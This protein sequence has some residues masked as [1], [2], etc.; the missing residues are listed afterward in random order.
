MNFIKESFKTFIRVQV[1]LLFTIL[2]FSSCTTGYFR[3]RSRVKEARNVVKRFI[4]PRAD[5]INFKLISD[6]QGKPGQM[7]YQI[8]AHH[9]RVTIKGNTGVALCRGAYTYLKE[10]CHCMFTWGGKHVDI[11][12]SWP[13]YPVKR[14]VCPFKYTLQDNV[15][16]FGY[17]TPF[18]KWK[19]WER[20]LD[21]MA[22][23][24]YNMQRAPVGGEAIWR[25]VW[26]KFGLTDKELDDFFTG[27]AY[28]PWHRMGNIDKYDGP[29]PASFYPQTIT[30]QK[31]I[32]K[33]MRILGIHPI[34]PAFA[35]F[36]PSGF[37]KHFP[38]A[39]VRNI[40]SWAGFKP[41]YTTHI[42][43]P[44]SPYYKNIGK[45]YITEWKKEFGNVH[46]YMADSFNELTPPLSKNPDKALKEL[47]GF[48]E[49][50]YSSIRAGDPNGVWVM[51][52][53][54]FAN[55]ENFW[56]K[57]RASALLSRVPD[58][59]MIVIDLYAEKI[60]Q[61]KR[62]DN[63]FNKQWIFSV[64]PNWGGTSRLGGWLPHFAK[65]IPSLQ[66]LKN[67]GNLV[68]FGD[69]PEGTE[70]NA[71]TFELLSDAA[72]ADEPINL[73][74]WLRDYCT[75]R[76][77]ACPVALQQAWRQLT[78]SVY[79]KEVAYPYIFQRRP[80]SN[81]KSLIIG[82]PDTDIDQHY[83]KALGLYLSV[84]GR[85]KDNP[86]FRN[87]LIEL[88]VNY[89]SVQ[90]DHF[91]DSA[92]TEVEDNDLERANLMMQHASNILDGMD[93]LLGSHTLFR[94]DRWVNMARS[95]GTTKDEKNY[96]E[97]DAK[98]IITIWGSTLSE[99]SCRLWAG[100]VSDYYK[101]RWEAWFGTVRKHQ[102]FD[103]SKWEK[104]WIET[105]QDFS[106]RPYDDPL[107]EIPILLS[108]SGKW[109]L[110][111]SNVQSNTK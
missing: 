72:W 96:Y 15:C 49:A 68:G 59:K 56:T 94:L 110:S 91:I 54:L 79:G 28:L 76:Y 82:Y 84:A 37:K 43:D 103:Q 24:G 102:L 14:V 75:D 90:A 87:D 11:P 111:K 4:G 106:I 19:E 92:R 29:V 60:P 10:A 2:L 16:T 69:S 97:A 61:W 105:P 109:G 40:A 77:G 48:G 107:K 100:L 25:R 8:E 88:T 80:L 47:A 95:W 101:A 99:Y 13:D 55:N 20:Y 26:K 44:M 34:A 104:N 83:K 71:V 22:L 74:D 70:V 52:G 85:F 63:F 86:L 93:R 64:I 46:F 67:T 21:W 89:L 38:D 50:V 35:G 78:Q 27:P 33:R 30:L 45:A 7:I 12:E 41:P 73:D 17:T 31:K 65:E 62:L 36:V 5:G 51:M 53:W 23:H 98:R 18:Y 108:K 58:D 6:D 42:L 66:Y 32:L 1:Y 9:G 57:T 3:G 81:S 39:K